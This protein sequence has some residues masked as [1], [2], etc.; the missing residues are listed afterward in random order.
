MCDG[1]Q[2]RSLTIWP[3]CTTQ[4]YVLDALN[5]S[6]REVAFAMLYELVAQLMRECRHLSDLINPSRL[7]VSGKRQ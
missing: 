1:T 2:F 3:H 7:K 5:D 4:D 6:P